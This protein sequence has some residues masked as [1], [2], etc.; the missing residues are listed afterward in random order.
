MEQTGLEPLERVFW[1]DDTMNPWRGVA[2]RGGALERRGGDYLF[3]YLTTK[4][5]SRIVYLENQ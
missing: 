2:G 4:L 3:V 5:A 1:Y